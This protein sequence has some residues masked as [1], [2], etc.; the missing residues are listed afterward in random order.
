[1]LTNL[2]RKISNLWWNIEEIKD[3]EEENIRLFENKLMQRC[4]VCDS[5]KVMLEE[6]FLIIQRKKVYQLCCVHC[7]FI[8]LKEYKPDYLLKPFE[9]KKPQLYLVSQA[10]TENQNL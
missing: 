3:E 10:N 8:I 4:P 5:G 1:M 7:H 2:L 6:H 9:S